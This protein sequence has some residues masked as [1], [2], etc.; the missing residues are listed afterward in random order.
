L[1]A[2]DCGRFVVDRGPRR[3][4]VRVVFPGGGLGRVLDGLQ[5][6]VEGQ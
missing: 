4:R 6:V 5:R 1:A 3:V 2:R